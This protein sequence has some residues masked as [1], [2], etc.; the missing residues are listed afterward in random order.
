MKDKKKNQSLM[1]RL[2]EWRKQLVK[3][4]NGGEE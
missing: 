4:K 2:K 3:K 1:E